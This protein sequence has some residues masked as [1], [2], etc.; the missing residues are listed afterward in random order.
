MFFKIL[1]K[2]LGHLV[3]AEGLH[4]DD[5]KIKAIRNLKPH[6]NVK[7]LQTVIGIVNYYSKFIPFQADMLKPM[8]NLLRKETEW[9]WP[10]ECQLALEKVNDVLSN[11]AVLVHYDPKKPLTVAYDASPYGVGCVLSHIM[12]YGDERPVAYTLHVH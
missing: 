12:E 7:E 9:N 11:D 1:L 3:D 8:Y 4:P 6:E 5:E 2:F 10:S